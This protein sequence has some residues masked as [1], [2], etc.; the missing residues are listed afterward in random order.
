MILKIQ[1]DAM[2]CGPSCLAMIVKYYGKDV[3]IEQLR[4]ICSLG[5]D[6]V[7]L[8]GISKAAETIGLKTIGG[9][10]SLNTLAHEIPLPCI[11][12]WNQNHFVVVYKIKKHNKEKYTVYVA[13]PGKGH[14]TYTKEEF[15]EHWI[16]TKNNG[17]E[18]GIA[19]LLEP[20]EQ[21]YAQ[22]DTKAVPTQRRVKFLWNYLKKYKRFF[23]QLI[24]GLL[25][26]SL[27]QLI[28]P[29]L[30]Q[31]IVDTGIGG[32]DIGF[33]WLV[34]LAEMMLLFS[35]TAIEF[36]RSKI[37]LHISTRIN[38][39][40]ISDF[41]IK[42]M[43]LPMKFFDT[44]LM[45]DLL[46]RI[47]DHRRVEQFLTSSSLSLL[48]SFFTFLVFGVVLAVYNLG[49]FFVFLMGT[50]LYAGWI[51]LFLK[52]R[53]QLDYKY[54][55]QAGR[56]RNVTYQLLGGMQEI[57]LQGC[58]QR[59]RWE[60]E[61]VQA[62]LFKVN[63]QSLNLQQVQQAGS[64]TINEVKN[65]LI[66]VLAATAVI[67]G[68]MTLGMMLAVQYIIGQLN[69]P[70]EQLIQFIYSWQDVSISLDRMNE[71]HTETN[72]ENVERT[73][74]AYTDKTTEGHSLTIKD[75]SFKY[76]IY[77]LKDILSDINLSIPNG[78][79]T[80]I[81]GASGSGKTTLVK[82]LL[83]FYEP[84]NG[85]IQIGSANLSEYNLGWWRSQC[86]AVMQEGYLF[87]DTIA[88]NIAI[89]D[90]EPDIE[91][92]RHAARVAN[93]A[94]YIEALP[95]AYNTM[96][97]QDGQ[98]ISQGQRQRIL[99][100]RVVY[101]N[102]MFVFLDEATNALDANNE[103]AITENLSEFYKGKTV[104]V[105]AHRLSTVR[106]ADQIVVLDEGEIV[107][108]GTH[109][110]LTAKRGKYFALVKNQLELGN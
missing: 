43:K 62:D 13:D 72:E 68:N 97:G 70:V 104:V 108:V 86:G 88:R 6:G 99:I 58:E 103:R 31:A 64:I 78:K 11:V 14:V 96:I 23:T 19:L 10:L 30:T 21:F 27:L 28:F 67:H 79:V 53:R 9:R 60:W 24:L 63:L 20:T 34:L 44:K 7:S 110:E 55:E 89:S 107:E 42:L 29:F 74:T 25:L 3:S 90:D 106:D 52:K 69:S 38:I 8:L 45:G 4:K 73:R 22:N 50:S 91:R 16:S 98:G 1:Q 51:I 17:E 93:I 32:K 105:V 85:S 101:K 81:V 48:F 12:H 77:S 37:L 95:L 84:L 41:F 54:F 57:K 65:I 40:L 61:D 5:K 56:N 33:V 82:L 35:R 49:I 59:K 66:T 94:D 39:S 15:C 76:D 26:G 80:A 2:D 109:E 47:E 71:I 75:L 100:A 46:Q 18:K 36:I 102:P 87:S 83:G 92:I